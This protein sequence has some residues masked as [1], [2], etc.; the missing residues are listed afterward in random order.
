MSALR[1]TTSEGDSLGTVVT[2]VGLGL[3]AIVVAATTFVAA[4]T[5]VSDEAWRGVVESSIGG[6][7]ETSG[8]VVTATA[9]VVRCAALVLLLFGSLVLTPGG[10]VAVVFLAVAG[11]AD[12]CNESFEELLVFSDDWLVCCGDDSPMGTVTTEEYPP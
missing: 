6:G 4:V 10:A 5:V 9:A 8:A 11:V 7:L 12:S 3:V 1:G 2:P